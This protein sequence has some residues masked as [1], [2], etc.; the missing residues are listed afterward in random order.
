[1]RRVLSPRCAQLFMV[2]V[3]PF[4]H[5]CLFQVALAGSSWTTMR[6]TTCIGTLRT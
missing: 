5:G 1:M 6:W 4:S 2:V 3:F